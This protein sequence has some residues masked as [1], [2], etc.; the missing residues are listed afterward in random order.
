M[1]TTSTLQ[2]LQRALQIAEQIAALETEL[3]AVLS[4][5]AS[6]EQAS[7]ATQPKQTRAKATRTK[8]RK[9]RTVS[10]EARARM[11]A[12]Q[13]SRRNREKRGK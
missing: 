11:A 4:G 5:N 3:K 13:K 12:A 9:T 2:Q 1:S 8:A 7:V 6:E 10:P